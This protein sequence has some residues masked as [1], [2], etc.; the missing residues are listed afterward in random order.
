MKLNK[1]WKLAMCMGVKGNIQARKLT[2]YR[3]AIGFAASDKLRYHVWKFQRM[4]TKALLS[5]SLF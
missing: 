4:E 2:I 3:Y 5:K 1:D